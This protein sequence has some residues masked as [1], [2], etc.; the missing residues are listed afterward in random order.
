MP[1]PKNGQTIGKLYED[2]N[3][4]KLGIRMTQKNSKRLRNETYFGTIRRS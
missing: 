3:I 1:K 4:F 2:I